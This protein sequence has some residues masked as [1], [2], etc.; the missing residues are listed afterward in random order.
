MPDNAVW[1]VTGPE[2]DARMARELAWIATGGQTGIVGPESL[3]VRAQNTPN[4]TVRIMPGGFSIAATS[5]QANIGY[6]SAPW[7]SYMRAIYSPLTVEIDATGSSGG[8]TDVVGIVIDDPEFEGTSPDV[9]AHQYWRPHV[10]RNVGNNATRPEHFASL[11]RP[12]IPLAQVHVPANTATITD[13]MITDIRFMAVSRTHTRELIQ[14]VS[15]TEHFS[16]PASQTSWLTVATFSGIQQPQWATTLRLAMQL[17]PVYALDDSV[18]GQFRVRTSNDQGGVASTA[19]SLFVETSF[20]PSERFYMHCAGNI[21]LGSGAAGGHGTFELQI[22]RTNTS[23]RTGRLM[24]PSNDT[25]ICRAVG[26]VTYEEVPRS[27]DW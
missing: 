20:S 4:N 9:D 11:G 24:I 8:R 19:A 1:A 15:D 7:Q 14:D 27:V 16:I 21:G 17:G 18:N 25:Q 12:F 5:Q 6:T 2:H 23:S 13:S 10:A 26:R 3:E 22:R